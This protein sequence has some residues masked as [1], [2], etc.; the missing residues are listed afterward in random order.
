[1]DFIKALKPM[2]LLTFFFSDQKN[3]SLLAVRQLNMEKLF[4]I[5]F[6]G[7]SMKVKG[8]QNESSFYSIKINSVDFLFGT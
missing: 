5:I 1:M 8:F 6:R 2:Y 7:D 3:R 4:E